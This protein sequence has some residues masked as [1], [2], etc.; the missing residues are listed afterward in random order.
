MAVTPMIH[1]DTDDLKGSLKDDQLKE[2]LINSGMGDFI[3]IFEKTVVNKSL[4]AGDTDATI[5]LNNSIP[6]TTLEKLR[7]FIKDIEKHPD[8][9]TNDGKIFRYK[10]QL[11]RLKNFERRVRNKLKEMKGDMGKNLSI[12]KEHMMTTMAIETNNK[13][14]HKVSRPLPALPRSDEEIEKTSGEEYL[15]KDEIFTPTLRKRLGR[16]TNPITVGNATHHS[17]SKPEISPK[18]STKNKPLLT[19][20]INRTMVKEIN[21]TLEGDNNSCDDSNIDEE[22]PSEVS[23][24]KA[25]TKQ[26]PSIP[27]LPP[28]PSWKNQRFLTSH[29]NRTMMKEL[30]QSV[31]KLLEDD[32][33]GLGNSSNNDGNS[34]KA[35][36]E[37]ATTNVASSTPVLPPK[38]SSNGQYP[39]KCYTPS[40]YF[41]NMNRKEAEITLKET[42][43]NG[44]Y[45]FR[46]SNR[47]YCTLSVIHGKKVYHIGVKNTGRNLQLRTFGEDLHFLS[48]KDIVKYLQQYPLQKIAEGG[49]LIEFTANYHLP[50]TQ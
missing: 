30:S 26:P 47:Y 21:E 37:E 23:A 18:P 35:P 25:I 31:T 46:A 3:E 7:K 44:T 2:F 6:I 24:E 40:K 20:H 39:K 28:K 11:S 42:S 19:P 22:N 15:G 43:N 4:T 33:N 29:I 12:A 27:V 34:C 9:I 13:F 41:V 38:P 48:L 45:M 14:K 10:T 8:R 16:N 5:Q 32:H 50:R 1:G 17:L 49:D 36:E